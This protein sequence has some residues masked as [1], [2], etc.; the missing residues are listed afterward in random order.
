M[1][2][3]SVSDALS[4]AKKLMFLEKGK[5]SMNRKEMLRFNK[6]QDLLLQRRTNEG[7]TTCQVS[8]CETLVCGIKI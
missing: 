7:H 2:Y 5:L 1:T 8:D 4:F 6:S 3:C